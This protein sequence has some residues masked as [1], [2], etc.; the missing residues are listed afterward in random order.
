MANRAALFTEA[1][2]RRAV[3][4]VT[5]AGLLVT[6]VTIDQNGRISI[7]VSGAEAG[8]PATPNTWDDVLDDN[9]EAAE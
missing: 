8:K 2:V 7:R 1:D 9:C 5:S 4:G 3:K 6:G